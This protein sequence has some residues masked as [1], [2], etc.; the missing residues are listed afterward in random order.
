MI[1]N[2]YLNIYLLFGI[3]AYIITVIFIVLNENKYKVESFIPLVLIVVLDFLSIPFEYYQTVY[4]INE[5]SPQ[6]IWFRRKFI[7]KIIY[8]ILLTFSVANVDFE[9]YILSFTFFTVSALI[10]CAL[11]ASFATNF[12]NFTSVVVWI[13]FLSLYHA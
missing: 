10:N 6:E 3:V 13:V 2:L 12:I 7:I 9:L 11:N 1:Q 5:S 4:L 8:L